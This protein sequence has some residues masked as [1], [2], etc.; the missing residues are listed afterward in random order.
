MKSLIVAAIAIPALAACADDAAPIVKVGLYKN[1]LAVVTRKVT[2]DSTGTAVVDGSAR[3]AYGTFWHSADKPVTVMRTAARDGVTISFRAAPDF[4]PVLAEA[5]K[6]GDVEATA[7][8]VGEKDRVFAVSGKLIANGNLPT[9]AAYPNMPW[10]GNPPVS[11]MLTLELKNGSKMHIPAGLKVSVKGAAS[12]ESWLFTGTDRPFA[13]EYLSAGASWTPSY[14]LAFG[15]KGKGTLFMSADV[16]NELADWKDAELSLISGFPNLKFANVPSLL[17]GGVDFAAYKNAVEAA[18]GGDQQPWY[19]GRKAR[20]GGVMSQSVMMNYAPDG[21]AAPN[22]AAYGAAE[23]GA[24]SDIHYREVGKVTLGKGETLTLPLGAKETKVERLVDWDLN[25]RRDFW[26]RL[27]NEEFKPELWDAV[28]VRNP[29]GFP[30]TTAPME[31]VEDGRI[32]GQNPCA[33]TNPGDEAIVKVTKALSVK[34]MY[35]ERGAGKTLSNEMLSSLGVG[36]RLRFNDNDYRKE[37]VTAT[38]KL[39]NFRKE[40]AKLRVKK[41]FSGELVKS[42]VEPT[43][44]HDPPPADSRVNAVHE[45]TWEFELKAGETREVSFTYWLWVRM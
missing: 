40:T 10:S 15:E 23:A 32:L 37:I 9:G 19:Y 13:V 8:S 25:D 44:R 34:G 30:L 1:G 28:K 14:R 33:W 26:G 43:K 38:M 24:G 3:P 11:N 18:E 20:V 16:R 31:V 2:P 17:G 42:D 35:E 39:T 45:L 21:M 22:A 12:G 6:E 7:Y 41:T 36:E 4:A 27:M 5:E 29:F